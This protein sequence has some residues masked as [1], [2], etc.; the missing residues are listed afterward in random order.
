[1]ISSPFEEYVVF[2]GLEV[3]VKSRKYIGAFTVTNLFLQSEAIFLV[4]LL[5][6]DTCYDTSHLYVD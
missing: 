6:T 4:L 5:E 3:S 2:A 1:M